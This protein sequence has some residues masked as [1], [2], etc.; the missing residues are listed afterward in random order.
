LIVEVVAVRVLSP[1]YGAACAGRSIYRSRLLS[2]ARMS[3][4]RVHTA[5]AA[6]VDRIK[7][8]KGVGIPRAPV[9]RLDFLER[10]MF[11]SRP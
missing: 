8:F 10:P 5:G 3:A 7:V 6:V 9:F 2:N 4:V 1:F 11:L